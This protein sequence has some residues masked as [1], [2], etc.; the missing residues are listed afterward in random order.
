MMGLR[1]NIAKRLEGCRLVYVTRDGDVDDRLGQV[2]E[3]F[4]LD[5]TWLP[6]R[7]IDGGDLDPTVQAADYV[8]CPKMAMPPLTRAHLRCLCERNGKPLLCLNSPSRTCFRNAI[9]KLAA[10]L[11]EHP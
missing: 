11:P 9:I 5:V 7:R 2:A 3:Y 1:H 8:L 10:A 6:A 4:S